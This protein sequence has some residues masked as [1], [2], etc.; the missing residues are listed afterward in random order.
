MKKI[1]LKN[2]KQAAVVLFVLSICANFSFSQ[3]NKIEN[4]SSEDQSSKAQSGEALS[5]VSKLPSI[6]V[7]SS[8]LNPSLL[9]YGKPIS[10]MDEEEIE[11]SMEPTLGEAVR[12]EPGVRSSFFGQGSSRPVIRGFAGDRV[13]V[14]RNGVTTGDVSDVSEDHVVVADPMQAKQIEILRGPETLLYGSGAIGGA[15]NVT[16]D[17]IPET[18]LGKPMEA[19]LLGQLGNS[20]D[21]EKTLGVKLRGESGKFNWHVSG[22][23]RETD[24][25]SIPSFAESSRLRELEELEEGE[26]AHDEE[27]ETEGRVENSATETWGATLGGSYVWNKGFFGVS[28]SGFGSD[29]G[30][31]GHVEGEEHGKEEEEETVQIESE[32]LRVDLRGRVD[33][34][35]DFIESV[36][37]KVGLTDYEHD[38]IE[39]GSVGS[40]YERDAID[41]RFDF[42]HAPIAGVSGV[43]G[44]QFI[45]DDFS[46]VGEEAFLNPTK[47]WAPAFFIYEQLELMDS[48]DLRFGGRIEVVSYDPN[49]SSSEN[50]VPFSL[51]A[52]PIWNFGEEQNYSLGLTFAYTE[53]AP[54]AVELFANG[55]HLARQIFE[56]GN[57]SLNK[58][59]SWGVDFALR[60]NTGIITGA[61]SPFYQNFSNYINLAGTGAEDDGFNVFRYEG[62]DAYFWGYEFEAALHFDQ[63]LDMGRN[64]F[65]LEFQSD[66]VRARNDDNGGNIARIP[67]LRNIVRASYEFDNFFDAMVESVFVEK[68]DDIAE[69]EIPTGSYT[70]LNAELSTK[71]PFLRDHDLR[72]FARGRNLTNDEARVHSSFLKDLAPLRGRSFLFGVRAKL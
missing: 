56:I 53:R 63:M 30:V 15:V 8:P 17:S 60:K 34:V 40:T 45:Y 31:P 66:F 52:G 24:D 58:E 4:S 37:I 57:S 21:E 65:T 46:A 41:A 67:S 68:Q 13:K 36:K 69:F 59:K 35:S 33:D 22:F 39:G 49:D 48:L 9:E 28:V 44:L 5:K 2:I 71:L 10:V 1:I 62:I 54:N 55:A 50:F 14:L 19:S 7:S 70:L 20:A 29:Y 12:L 16:D 27:E 18:S 32:Q 26:D 43:A 51:S 47:T 23:A 25:Y 38:E 72:L 6:T 42:L 64:D 3:N 61:F 11:S